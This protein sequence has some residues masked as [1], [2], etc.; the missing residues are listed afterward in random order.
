MNY[1]EK[2]I[3]LDLMQSDATMCFKDASAA[4]MDGFDIQPHKADPVLEWQLF[5]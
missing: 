4:F 5:A 3:Q 2:S 1:H